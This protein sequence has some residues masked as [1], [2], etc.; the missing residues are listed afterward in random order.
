VS[1]GDDFSTAAE[2]EEEEEEAA[3][4]GVGAGASAGAGRWFAAKRERHQAWRIADCTDEAYRI[5]E[6]KLEN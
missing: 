5:S 1:R 2:E 4:A 6:K 3:G